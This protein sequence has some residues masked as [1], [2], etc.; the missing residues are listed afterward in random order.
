MA[1]RVPVSA[2]ANAPTVDRIPNLLAGCPC[3]AGDPG[4][5][6]RMIVVTD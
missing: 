4:D 2:P 1:R 3:G 6:S 5:A